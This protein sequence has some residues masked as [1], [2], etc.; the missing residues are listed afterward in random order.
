MEYHAGGVVVP[1]KDACYASGVDKQAYTTGDPLPFR[2]PRQIYRCCRTSAWT[3]A[4][5]ATVH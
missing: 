2:L 5:P 1:L 4:L 3:G